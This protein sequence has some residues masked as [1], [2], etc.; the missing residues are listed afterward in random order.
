MREKRILS[1]LS[2]VLICAFL[3]CIPT[4][5]DDVKEWRQKADKSNI[6]VTYSG[7]VAWTDK[8]IVPNVVT[9]HIGLTGEE[10][11]L[12]SPYNCATLKI[13]SGT[14][15]KTLVNYKLYYGT[16][17]IINST[18]KSTTAASIIVQ[19]AFDGYKEEYTMK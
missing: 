19:W 10:V 18:S 9:Y 6:D 5:A 3:M 16:D 1:I 2:V 12:T 15:H 8:G 13:E 7:R 11:K 17:T 14:L 4:F